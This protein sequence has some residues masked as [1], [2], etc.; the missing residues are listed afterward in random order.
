MNS[1]TKVI[2][3]NFEYLRKLFIMPDSPDK[4]IEFGRELL[5]MIHDFFREKGGIHSSITLPQLSRIFGQT[6]IPD[7]PRLIKDVL[8]EV[9]E[10]VIAHSVKVG[11]PYYIGHMTSA[12]PY[13]MIL[14]EMIIAAL[15]QNQVKIETAKASSFVE[16]ELVAWFHRLIFQKTE[17]FYQKNIQNPRVALGNVTADGTIS[18]LT[19]LTV[20]REKAFPPDGDFPGV[21]EAGVDQAMRHYGFGRGAILVSTRGHYSIQKAASLLGIGE[22]N[23]FTIPVDDHHRIDCKKLYQRI[24]TLRRMKG[25]ERTKIIAVIGIAGTTETGNIDPLDQVAELANEAGAYYHVDACWG[26]SALLVGEYRPLLKGIEC[27]DSVSIDAHKL[28][29]C[30]MSMGLLIF[31]NE[32]DLNAIKQSSQYIIRRNSVDMGRFTIEGSRPFSSL[33]PWAF[34]KIIGRDGYRLLFR[35]AQENTQSLQEILEG[36]G[37]FEI[38]NSPELFILIYR[39][40]P[41]GVR[42]GVHDW[43][44]ERETTASK[45]R[46]RRMDRDIRKVNHLINALNIKLHKAL[47]QDDTTFV[48]RTM[49]ESTRYRPQKIVVLRAVLMNPLTDKSTLKEIVDTQNRIGWEIWQEF[50]SAYQRAVDGMRAGKVGGN[51][52]RRKRR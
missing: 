37:N 9:K 32:K 48:S 23:V 27:A 41:Q 28:L 20:A 49:L 16:R 24:K 19:A 7:E 40:I 29:Y 50:E 42:E 17:S 25:R 43:Q 51:N 30:P 14:L 15:N 36:C 45:T 8:K 26:G 38:L 12:I 13:F 44:H 2:K 52:F 18:N 34:L 6:V 5:E 3:S 21:R 1:E 46:I 33:K 22:E 10:K 11:S 39:F 4:F 35:S 47:R 31:R